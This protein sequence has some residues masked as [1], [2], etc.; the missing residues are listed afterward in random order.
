MLLLR[1]WVGKE[2]KKLPQEA[3][4]RLQSHLMS[5]TK[6]LNYQLRCEEQEHGDDYGIGHGNASNAD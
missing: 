4:D 5:K 1:C 2:K 3:E 6:C